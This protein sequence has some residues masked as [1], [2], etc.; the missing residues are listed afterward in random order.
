MRGDAQ[1]LPHS[2]LTT[3]L[4]AS[5]FSALPAGACS[6][7]R[8]NFVPQILEILGHS[9]STNQRE[10]CLPALCSYCAKNLLVGNCV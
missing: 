2:P 9:G 1:P 6:Q 10:T 4:S 3:P 8:G 7:A 5:S